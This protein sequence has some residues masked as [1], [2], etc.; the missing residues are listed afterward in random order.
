[1][2]AALA[3]IVVLLAAGAEAVTPAVLSASPALESGAPESATGMARPPSFG[4]GVIV[5]TGW[6]FKDT[7]FYSKGRGGLTVGAGK[8]FPVTRWLAV[9]AGAGALRSHGTLRTVVD[10]LDLDTT[11]DG[12]A[13]WLEAGVVIPWLPFPV[14]L[15]AYRHRTDL[16][17]AGRNGAL[18]G[19]RLAG[20][21]EGWGAGG[22]V[23]LL[24]EY[25]IANR[26]SGPR[27][28]GF[29]IE[30]VG[31][32]DLSGRTIRTADAAG[33]TADH[34]NWKPVKGEALRVGLEYEF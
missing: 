20:S 22:V 34:R 18:A 14:A 5:T 6:F 13:V 15:T 21:A 23:H 25:F 26:R 28:L 19:R 7:M 31:F 2:R 3:G 30:Y 29:A 1:M 17:D 9:W 12:D 33:Y 16:E 8:A 24:F 11:F 10:G 27:G 4:T 32:M